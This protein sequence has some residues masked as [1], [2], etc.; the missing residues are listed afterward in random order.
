MA[1]NQVNVSTTSNDVTVSQTPRTTVTVTSV[2]IQGPQGPR[3]EGSAEVEALNI[4]SGSIQTEVDNLT[5][6]TG[7]YLTEVPSGTVSGSSQITAFGFISESVDITP[8]NNFSGSIQTEVNSLTAATSSYLTDVPEGTVSSSA[9]LATEI[10]GAF[11][12]TSA[13]LASSITS[14]TGL[15]TSLTSKT[16]SYATTGSNSFVGD[17][18]VDG[19]ITITGNLT[20]NQYIVSSSVTFL[21]QSFS[22]GS[23]IF[24]DTSDDTHQFTGSVN[25]TGSFRLNNY[26]LPETD[27][28]AEQ[29]IITDGAGNLTFNLLRTVYEQVKNVSGTTLQKGTP[30]HVTGS[31]GNENTVIAASASD[32]STMPATFILNETLADE[33]AGLGVAIGFINGVN[34]SE[35]IE[36][37]VVYVGESGGY[38]NVQPTGS[39]LIQ[40]L[41]IV[42]KAAVNGSGVVLGAGR[43]NAVPNLLNGQVFFGENNRAVSKAISEIFSEASYVYSGSF[44]GSFEGDG[45]NLTGIV[46]DLTPLNTFTG[47]IQTEV[48]NLTAATSSYLTEVPSGTVSGSAQITAFGFISESVDISS[49][50]TFTGSIQTEVD[51]IEAVTGSFAT[52]GSNNF[53]GDQVITG[54]LTISGS[55]TFTNIGPAVF[56]GSVRIADRQLLT[57][58]S[59]PAFDNRDDVSYGI[60][61]TDLLG[62][63]TTGLGCTIIGGPHSTGTVIGSYN[64]IIGAEALDGTSNPQYNVA[65]GANTLEGFGL[66]PSFFD[67]VDNNVAIGYS[68]G[69]FIGSYQSVMIG[70]E[71]GSQGSTNG[72]DI[73]RDSVFLGYRSAKYIGTSNYVVDGLGK[74]VAIGSETMTNGYLSSSIAIGYRSNYAAATG[75][76]RRGSLVTLLGPYTNVSQSVNIINATGIGA[77]VEIEQ[78]NTVILG[79]NA[80]VGIGTATPTAKLEVSGSSKFVGDQVITG[81]LD[82]QADNDYKIDGQRVIHKVSGS[83]ILLN[84]NVDLFEF[85]TTSLNQGNIIIGGA[86][87]GDAESYSR[88]NV[89]IGANAHQNL[90]GS[91]YSTVIGASA[92]SMPT[93]YTQC[94]STTLVGANAS[95]NVGAS[96]STFIGAYAGWS[97]STGFNNTADFSVYVGR[98][99]GS[100]P[101]VAGGMHNNVAVGSSA[102]E[103]AYLS[104]SVALGYYAGRSSSD[105]QERRGSLVTL[106][107]PYTNVSQSVNIINATAIGANV[108]VE[109]SNT[110][111]LGNNADVGIGTATPTAKLE[112]SGSVVISDILTLEPTHPAPTSAPSG[113]IISSGSGAELKPYFWNGS[114]WTSMI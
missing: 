88:S 37:D 84:D 56:S 109:Q 6:A 21:T 95:Q 81:S 55:S 75:E 105:G 71:A 33:E 34:T 28:T 49:L 11:V 106:L 96:Y 40:N 3:G 60:A 19:N 12:E 85:N 54:S 52:T 48:D 69:R 77:N 86:T 108:E 4:F 82:L 35:F 63:G 87:S 92:G 74:N 14:N 27:G 18:N 89:I 50:N 46:T 53:V 42:T 25:I 97:L 57:K 78:S 104:S 58:L 90:P 59:D 15:I 13:S 79:N 93:G 31:V 29:I 80:D 22:S 76:E 5:A 8:L 68:A 107:G 98:S 70:S 66:I 24:G 112:V 67:E 103:R 111:I 9:Q 2:G 99:A 45:S 44:S 83:Y 32:A 51:S 23:T 10:S 20:A 91:E 39:N 65:I 1:Q 38:T 62:V 102:M 110:V 16:G 73:G 26:N 101:Q 94:L 7:S 64:T 41:G 114:T 72:R 30:V 43:T 113:S 61:V 17:Q 100:R 47:S 36:G